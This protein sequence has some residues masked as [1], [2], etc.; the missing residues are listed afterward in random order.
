MVGV[1]GANATTFVKL[2]FDELVAD[3]ALVVDGQVTATRSEQ[4]EN[5][6]VTYATVAV[7][8]SVVGSAESTLTILTPGGTA[9]IGRFK[10]GETWPGAPTLLVGERAFFFVE[11]S[12]EAGAYQVTGFSQGVM[13][14][15]TTPDGEA[16]V[17]RGNGGKP[18]SVAEMKQR[19]KAAKAKGRGKPIAD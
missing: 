15:V 2:S 13:E 4:T 19:I 5:G 18:T 6:I 9:Q 1:V 7:S 17:A 3:S 11:N 16:M 14:I 8:D 12:V 10:I